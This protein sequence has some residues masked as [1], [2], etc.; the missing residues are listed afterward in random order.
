MNQDQTTTDT[1]TDVRH[2]ESALRGLDFG[3]HATCPLPERVRMLRGNFDNLRAELAARDAEIQRLREY[4][5]T[6]RYHQQRHAEAVREIEQ[7]RT[8]LGTPAGQSL[9]AWATAVMGERNE[10]REETVTLTAEIHADR[11][12]NSEDQA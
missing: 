10:L 8:I 6:T 1:A 9:T 4:A 11:Q 12:Q 7:V 3:D 2:A 5:D